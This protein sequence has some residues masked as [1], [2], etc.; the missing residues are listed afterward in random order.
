MKYNLADIGVVAYRLNEGSGLL[1]ARWYHSDLDSG[2][3]GTGIATPCKASG[4]EGSFDITYSLAGGEAVGTFK[5]RI[6]RISETFFLEWL[7]RDTLVYVG[8]GILEDG[9]LSAGWRKV[10]T[11]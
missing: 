7:D 4:F 6:T 8:L 3:P 5:L 1:E 10:R 11:D 9:T 2:Q